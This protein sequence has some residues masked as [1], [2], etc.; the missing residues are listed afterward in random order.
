MIDPNEGATSNPGNPGNPTETGNPSDTDALR[1]DMEQLRKDIAALGSNAKHRARGQ[2]QARIDQA[3]GRFDSWGH[4][5]E[6]RPFT[7]IMVAF[8]SG[9]LLGKLLG[10]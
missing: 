6:A 5:I 7:S 4:E 9:L 2:A 3:C 8:G 10:R 1:K